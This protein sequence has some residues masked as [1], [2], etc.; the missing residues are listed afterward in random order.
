MKFATYQ[1]SVMPGTIQSGAAKVSADPNAY[2]GWRDSAATNAG[3]W[4]DAFGQMEKVYN[5]VQDDQDA[6]DVMEARNK[7]M[8]QLNQKYY[9]SE[10]GLFTTGIGLNAK[11]LGERVKQTADETFN[12]VAAEYNGRVQRT[13]RANMN[14][15]LL[16]KYQSGMNQE[17]SEITKQQDADFLS[18]VNNT[19]NDGAANWVE[20][21]ALTRVKADMNSLVHSYA[22]RKGFSGEQMQ[23]LM[24]KNN[25]QLYSLAIAGAINSGDMGR[26]AEILKNAKKDMNLD[27]WMDLDSKVK[28]DTKIRDVDQF[29][30]NEAVRRSDGTIDIAATMELARRK[31]KILQD[32]SGAGKSNQRLWANAQ[33][34]AEYYYQKTGKNINPEF[35]YGQM[36]HESDRGEYP[37][38]LENNN[39]AGL[40]GG[41]SGRKYK[42]DDEFCEDYASILAQDNYAGLDNAKTATDFATI[43]HN[44][45]YFTDPNVSG[46]A[47][48]VDRFGNE[49]KN[50]GNNGAVLPT[51]SDSITLQVQH[52]KPA[53][54]N[55]A[56]PAISQIIRD[57]VGDGAAISSAARSKEHN[58]VSN[59]QEYSY[60]IDNGDGGDALDIVLPD[61][62]SEA[63]INELVNKFKSTGAFT[64]VLYHD[65]GSGEHLHLG[66]YNGGLDN[67]QR[68]GGSRTI[69]LYT[70]EELQYIQHQLEARD[71]DERREKARR[72]QEN[73][74]NIKN[75]IGKAGSA[76]AA[77]AYVEGL[78]GIDAETKLTARNFAKSYWGVTATRS[79]SGGRSSS[80]SSTTNKAAV[81]K[82]NNNSAALSKFGDMLMNEE[83]IS[84]S[85]FL[86]MRE[87][88]IIVGESGMLS[89]EDQKDY[90]DLKNDPEFQS[91]LTDIIENNGGL[92]GAVKELENNGMSSI[93]AYALISKSHISY[94]D[95]QN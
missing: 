35:L 83:P 50:I 15:Y 41:S 29:I 10:D 47:S 48:A 95:Y 78:S 4:K 93:V 23:D 54:Q 82:F 13:L 51:Q 44:G 16:S 8:T 52:L 1:R 70:Q 63:Q 62:A 33:K 67:Q 17:T 26:A 3:N 68:G 12:T 43:L 31:T 2:G 92:R 7:I 11:G 42:D 66:G 59:G 60:H 64:E 30:T 71:A 20:N 89:E 6:A 45:G 85:Q 39:F 56:L 25:T 37:A 65:A 38:A 27:A 18:T 91:K 84:K 61:E 90:D 72:D 34:A 14:E 69:P 73:L 36:M 86:K 46:Y 74:S 79:S 88:G 75:A 5:K 77:L 22:I 32:D 55:G 81:T 94:L 58:A 28:K 9:N 21:G 53:W 49:G 80:R 87:A 24:R 57:S 76:A 40:H 19:I